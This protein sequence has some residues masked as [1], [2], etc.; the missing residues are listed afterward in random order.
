MQI[1]P[2]DYGAFLASKRLAAP[3][4]GTVVDQATL[5]PAMKPHQR[6][7]TAW[8]I[9]KGRAACWLDTGL[10]KALIGLEW[11][12][13]LGERTL[14]LAPLGVAQQFVHSEGPK[15]GIPVTY[16]RSE[17]EAPAT[18]IVATNYERLANFD[19][20]KW[21]AWIL[22]EASIL[23]N[24]SG[25]IKR[26]LVQRGRHVPYRLTL[27]ATPAPNDV[28]ELCNQADFL[29]VMGQAAM[30]A[31]FFTP[32][33]VEDSANGNYRLKPHAR[34]DFYRWLTT[35]AIACKAPSD[36][37]YPD[38]GY[39]LP[40]LDIR[41]EIVGTE[42][43]PEG[44]LFLTKLK[45]VSHRA[46]VRR[47]TIRERLARVAAL[48]QAEPEEQWL[49]WYGLL[50]EAA[51]LERLLPGVVVLRG[52]DSAERK[53]DVLLAFARGE[54]R[55]LLTHQKIAGMGMNFQNCA[56][57]AFVGIDDSYVTYYQA[58]RRCWRFGQT[59]PVRAHLI[60]AEPQRAVHENVLRK[61][62]EANE[63]TRGLVA[64]MRDFERADLAGTQDVSDVYEPTKP[65]RLPAWLRGFTPT[66][67]AAVNDVLLN[68]ER[69]AVC[70]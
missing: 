8:A 57:T 67:A 14:I 47:E 43:A 63:L 50:D 34:R 62:A 6:A 42:W 3:T 58:I 48:V 37:G 54:V 26:Q 9:R 51:Q 53:A 12:R 38:D 32:K 31:R 66:R 65:V 45:G 10:G 28:V 21:G 30:L 70:A 39:Q 59:R 41:A 13:T 1:G 33:G 23:A 2:T 29:G 24:F 19:P 22:D 16:A 68:P 56:R 4:V 15:W 35:W 7:I 25:T 40:P 49:L 64:A 55:W 44:Q 60:L 46:Q 27:T 61:E 17:D 69:E 20:A 18:G 36:L 11:A 5:H 52:S